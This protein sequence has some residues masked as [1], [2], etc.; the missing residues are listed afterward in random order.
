M[1]GAITVVLS[2][3][4]TDGG[5]PP[6]LTPEALIAAIS[7]RSFVVFTIIYLV[8]AVVLAGLSEGG[9]GRRIVVVDVGLCAIFGEVSL[10]HTKYEL[11]TTSGGFTVLAT[12]AI[13]TLL[14]EEWGKIFAEWITY[15]VLAVS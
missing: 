14:T 11:I 5:P 15:P 3:P 6:P 9:F 1:I 10:N 8:G 4:S 13:S 2:T 12:K 7:Q